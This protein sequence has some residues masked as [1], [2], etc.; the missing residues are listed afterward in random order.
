MNKSGFINL[1]LWLSRILFGIVF[2]FSGFV[3]AIDPLGSTYKFQDYFLAFDAQWLFPTALPLAILM[4]ALEFVI[5]VTVLLGIKMRYSAW[6]GLLFMLFFTPLTLYIAVFEPVSD[7]GCFGDALVISNWA[8][9][10]K[11]IFILAAAIF[12]FINRHKVK[13]LW[14]ETRDWYLVAAVSL[15]I[16]AL[17][18]YCLRNLPLMDFRPWKIGNN[19]AEK[20]QPLQEEIAEYTFIYRN[21]E[22]GQTKEFALD[23]LPEADKGWEFVDRK[24][25]IIQP[26]I[27]A[28]IDDFVIQDEDGFDLTENYLG[29]PDYQFLLIAYDLHRTNREAFSQ[30]INKFAQKAEQANVSF[31]VLTASSFEDIDLFRH[32]MQAAY[33]FYQADGIKLK[34]IIR[35]N[36][37]LVLMKDWVV[38]DKW[39]HRNI[40]EFEQVQEQYMNP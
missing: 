6:G 19:I 17:S 40:P 36:P 11:N 12:I 14:S 16:V 21:T 23:Q 37:G 32:E 28:P 33:P 22:T 29:N 24:E 25:E 9:F 34:T 31:I 39:A 1:L 3:K 13:P 4:S 5:G 15:F 30:R 10:Y 38:I 27:E 35:S 2:I 18:V 8:T 26:F 20:M 7:C